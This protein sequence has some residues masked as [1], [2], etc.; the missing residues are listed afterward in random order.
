MNSFA[1]DYITAEELS[2]KWL[3]EILADVWISLWLPEDTRET[4]LRGGYYTALVRPGFRVIAL[5]NMYCYM[6]NWS[7]RF[8]TIFSPLDQ[9]AT[10]FEQVLRLQVAAP[11]SC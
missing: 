5:N 4:I 11:R 6:L 2:T 10:D 1:P 7:E 3:Y 8:G 9:T